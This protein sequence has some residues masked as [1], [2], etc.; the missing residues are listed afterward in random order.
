MGIGYTGGMVGDSANLMFADAWVKNVRTFDVEEAYTLFRRTAFGPTPAMSAYGDGAGIESYMDRGYVS[1]DAAG[2]E[3]LA[4]ARVRLQRLGLGRAG[5]S[6]GRDRGRRHVAR[7]RQQLAQCLGRVGAVLRGPQ[8]GRIVEALED[9][10]AWQDYFAEGN[11]WQYVWYVPHDMDG[12]AELM[13][14]RTRSSRDSISSSPTRPS[15]P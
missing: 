2:S 5:R 10:L 8:R 7:A 11:V 4:Y 3:H 15:D 6:G 1:M 12:L 13:G 9:P 14:G